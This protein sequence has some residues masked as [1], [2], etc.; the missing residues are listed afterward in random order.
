MFVLLVG[1]V[2]YGGMRYYRPGSTMPPRWERTIVP[3]VVVALVIGLYVWR[4]VDP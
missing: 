4:I 3:V 2:L 1:A